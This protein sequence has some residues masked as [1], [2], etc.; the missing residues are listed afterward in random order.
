LA[1][2]RQTL[3]D[4]ADADFRRAV[5]SGKRASERSACGF[6]R[7]P[8][9]VNSTTFKGRPA[10]LY[11]GWCHVGCPIGALANPLVTYLGEARRAGA[12]V[13]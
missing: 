4:A 11:D 8:T 6:C 12:E 7:R 1:A 3:S 13:R 10:C 2:R 5:T 9:G